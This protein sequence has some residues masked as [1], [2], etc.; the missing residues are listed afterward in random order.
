MAMTERT[1]PPKMNILDMDEN[2]QFNLSVCIG[3]SFAAAG[4]SKKE[5]YYIIYY[6][7]S[8][9]SRFAEGSVRFNMVCI[10]PELICFDG[11]P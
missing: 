5:T 6:I 10:N 1:V 7:I 4:V 3:F 2:G 8:T 11:E 9:G